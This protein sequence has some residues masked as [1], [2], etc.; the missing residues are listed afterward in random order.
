MKK[1]YFL[2]HNIRK[3]I[4][5]LLDENLHGNLKRKVFGPEPYRDPNYFGQGHNNY[6]HPRHFDPDP[7]GFG[8]SPKYFGRDPIHYG[9]GPNDLRGEMRPYREEVPPFDP[10]HSSVRQP[11][12]FSEI[13]KKDI[14][15]ESIIRRINQKELSEK[16]KTTMTGIRTIL[17]EAG[18]IEIPNDWA[19]SKLPFQG[20]VFQYM[21]FCIQNFICSRGNICRYP[22]CISLR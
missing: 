4:P 3:R 12:D 15:Y 16:Y 6:P 22:Q 10:L 8:P 18:F 5:S 11:N 21:E 7:N 17:H 13:E 20:M 2:P 19:T 14:V 9:P 1:V